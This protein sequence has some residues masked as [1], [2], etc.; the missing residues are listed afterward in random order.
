M[1]LKMYLTKKKTNPSI[2]TKIENSNVYI[3]VYDKDGKNVLTDHKKLGFWRDYNNL[4]NIQSAIVNV[5]E[6]DTASSESLSCEYGK[7]LSKIYDPQ[8]IPDGYSIDENVLYSVVLRREHEIIDVICLTAPW[9]SQQYEN[10][11]SNF[12]MLDISFYNK[13]NEIITVTLPQKECLMGKGIMEISAHGAL[14]IESKTKYVTNWIA[15]YIHQNN[16]PETQI[17]DR[18]GWK[19]NN[20]FLLGNK[21]YTPQGVQ[22]AKLVNVPQKNI[23]C[24]SQKGTIEEWLEMSAPALKYPMTRFK[25]YASC[26]APLLKMLHLDSIAILDYGK[27]QTGKT[28]TSLVAMSLWGHPQDQKIPNHSTDVGIELMLST[29]T[30]IPIF[31][32]EMQID[33]EEKNQGLVYRIANG[34][35]KRKGSKE[36]GMQDITFWSTIAFLTGEKTITDGSSLEGVTSRLLEIYGGLGEKN[37]D[38]LKAIETFAAGVVNNY[39]VFAPYVIEEIRNHPEDVLDTY[40][41]L[42]KNYKEYSNKLSGNEKGI[43]GRAAAMFAVITLGGSIFEIIMQRLGQPAFDS[44]LIAYKMFEAYINDLKS[45]NYSMKAYEYVMSWF[46]SKQKYFL[47]DEMEKGSRTPYELYGNESDKYIDIFPTVLDKVLEQG[48]FSKKRVVEDWK[49]DGILSTSPGRH[50]KTVRWGNETK[51]VYRIIKQ[52]PGM[53]LN[54]DENEHLF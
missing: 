15:T 26:A 23:D 30:D 53:N 34:A 45:N 43:G 25:C 8:V 37:E 19:D 42:Y 2:K 14:L 3:N 1:E 52:E 13:K 21:L 6:C 18:F 49:H 50:Q 41:F 47:A 32:D 22:P 17:F 36:G 20:S 5:T 28:F 31:I 44:Q 11:D 24:F 33:N 10:P 48:G 35:G 51:R 7:S 16:I 40:E 39:G 12:K 46:N 27:S 4:E 38:T 29:N 9:V 54:N